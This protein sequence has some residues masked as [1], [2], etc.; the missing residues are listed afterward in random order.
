MP[1]DIAGLR[2]AYTRDD[3]TEAEAPEDPT[4]LFERWFADACDCGLEDPNA[5]TLATVNAEG[6]P[7]ARI[8]LLKGVDAEGFIFY[9]NYTSRKGRELD[10]TGRAA[11]VFYWGPLERQVRVEGTV[12]RVS[13]ELSDRY[14]ASRPE[15]S[16]LGLSLIHI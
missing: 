8:V 6:R 15:G 14:F 13:A 5:M 2:R 7:S 9:T 4:P 12:A 16:R 3:L 1:G 11:L 10:A